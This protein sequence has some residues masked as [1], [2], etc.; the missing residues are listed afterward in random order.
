[1]IGD[2]E[3]DIYTGKNAGAKTCAVT[4]GYRTKEE[5]MKTNPDLLIDKLYDLTEILNYSNS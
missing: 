3:L 4:Y 1:M 2:S 5:L